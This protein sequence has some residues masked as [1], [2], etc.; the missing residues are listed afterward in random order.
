[1]TV[2][3][4]KACAAFLSQRLCIHGVQRL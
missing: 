1:M 2:L 3:N 4:T